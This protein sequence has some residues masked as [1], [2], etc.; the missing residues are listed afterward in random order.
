MIISSTYSRGIIQPHGEEGEN[1]AKS[2]IAIRFCKI[3]RDNIEALNQRSRRLLETIKIMAKASNLR[4][5]MQMED[6]YLLRKLP[7]SNA[8]LTTIW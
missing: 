8:Y 7:F 3:E 5:K 1:H 4:R 2:W 6:I